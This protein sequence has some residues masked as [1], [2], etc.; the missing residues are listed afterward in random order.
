MQLSSKA[1]YSSLTETKTP[2]KKEKAKNFIIWLIISQSEPN[3]VAH[4]SDKASFLYQSNS[5]LRELAKNYDLQSIT[6][7]K[8]QTKW[9]C[10]VMISHLFCHS[11]YWKEDVE[12]ERSSK[13][14]T[15]KHRQK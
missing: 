9:T 2:K 12:E 15:N 8:I 1:I 13:S 10:S 7:D 4:N 5:K 11:N 6:K 3:F 14:I